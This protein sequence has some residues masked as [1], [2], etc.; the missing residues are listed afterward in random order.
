MRKSI[1]VHTYPTPLAEA[2]RHSPI[3]R[4][5][6]ALL[7]LHPSAADEAK[8]H[9]AAPQL[10]PNLK[11][12]LKPATLAFLLQ[13]VAFLIMFSSWVLLT[14]YTELQPNFLALALMQG[15]IAMMLSGI[16]GMAVWWRFIQ[17]MFPL[18]VLFMHGLSIPPWLYLAGFLLTLGLFWTTFRTQVPFF[19]S[20][21][22]VWQQVA[23]YLPSS[24]PIRLMDIGSGLGD[25]LIH[26]AAQRPDSH[27]EG[28]EIAPIPWLASR[29]NGWLRKSPAAFHLG[30]YERM[31]F[32]AYDVVFAYLSPA[33]MPALWKKASQEMRP[34]SIL[35]SYE[36][37][38][39]GVPANDR[40]Q[41]DPAI[42]PIY[43]WKF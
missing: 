12:R 17:L 5:A 21:E 35:M 22:G 23:D 10:K 19:P 16:M 18:A 30:N 29:M 37:E 43:V 33:A 20:H 42:P 8:V 9:H 38:I 13:N 7:P 26:L 1:P 6:A 2:P 34:G 24:K 36:F 28:I 4:N 41:S 40:L 32:A 15:A 27:F 3:S 14:R 39:D 25:L 11:P 31:N